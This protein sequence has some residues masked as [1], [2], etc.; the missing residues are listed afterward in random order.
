MKKII[1][2]FVIFF[3]AALIR[4]YLSN[5]FQREIIIE[6]VREKDIYFGETINLNN[7]I[8]LSYS[9]GI[10]LAFQMVNRLGGIN[11]RKLNLFIYDDD[12]NKDKAVKNAK[13]LLEYENVLGLIGTWG[14]P[15]SYSI[16]DE[17]IGQ[18]NIPFIAPLTGSNLIK[19]SPD[20]IMM[21]RPS[22]KSEISVILNHLNSL[23]LRNI[24]VIYQNDE[25]GISCFNDLSDLYSLNNY[26]INIIPATYE[27]NSN[28]LY[29]AYKKILDDQDP[30]VN[31][32]KRNAAVL[33]LDVILIFGTSKQ[34]FHIIN[35]FK[36][37]KPSM[38]FYNISFVGDNT[39]KLKN[40]KNKSNIYLTNV[41]DIS[42]RNF[43]ILYNNLI[44]EVKISNGKN[45]ILNVQIN[46]NHNLIEGFVAGLFA[47]NILKKMNP[48][49]INRE[50]FI[51]ELYLD[52]ENYVQI[53][54]M[55]LGPFI[56]SK[57][58]RGL[59]TVYLSKY[60][61][62]TDKYNVISESKQIPT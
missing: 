14:T 3:I 12:Y 48:K 39:E 33:N 7:D 25:Y 13:I 37:L 40:I 28:Y 60:D 2:L 36:K 1:I 35:Y 20:N 34:E 62:K 15:T 46:L 31:S 47:A 51:K 4:Y 29:D 11:G 10:V 42:D 44:K 57:V 61:E 43:P 5:Y 21:L 50:N 53:F 56:S 16:Y 18:K 49:Y 24:A 30:F 58:S 32:Y 27:R 55:K 8:S 26:D 54:D 52:K 23:G 9:N 17:V 38:Y 19:S 22:Y 6:G 41:I 45:K 59:H